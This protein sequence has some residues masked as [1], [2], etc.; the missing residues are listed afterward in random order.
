MKVKDGDIVEVHRIV[1]F[2]ADEWLPAT[3][4][5]VRS[6]SFCV[7]L[8]HGSFDRYDPSVNQKWLR[9]DGDQGRASEAEWRVA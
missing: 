5:A 3:V 2:G 8:L 4:V 9:I 7:Q 6:N 1:M